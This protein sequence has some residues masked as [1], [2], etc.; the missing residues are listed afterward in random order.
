M[1]Q[2]LREKLRSF[3]KRVKEEAIEEDESEKTK[4]KAKGP[5][6]RTRQKGGKKGVKGAKV[7]DEELLGDFEAGWTGKN[8]ATWLIKFPPY[9]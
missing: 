1:F 2:S 7:K 5:V 9:E 3:K 8:L 6:K 4:T